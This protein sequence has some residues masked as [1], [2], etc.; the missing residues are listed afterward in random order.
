M[1]TADASAETGRGEDSVC[2]RDFIVDRLRDADSPM[3][4]AE[5]ADEYGCSNGHTQ[6]ELYDLLD[7]GE[8]ERVGVGE[9]VVAGDDGAQ[10]DADVGT[11]IAADVGGEQ[12]ETT[13]DDGGDDGPPSVAGGPQSEGLDTEDQDGRDGGLGI[14][15]EAAVVAVVIVLAVAYWR[16]KQSRDQGGQEPA[17]EPEATAQYAR[18]GFG[19]D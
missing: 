12:G 14:P 2:A 4:P 8:V 9:Y 11:E 7:E 16:L 3:S 13:G 18:G 19:G 6:N 1:A 5:L 15:K 17:D 10:S